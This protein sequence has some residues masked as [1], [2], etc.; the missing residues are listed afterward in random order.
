[1]STRED[2][3]ICH[4]DAHTTDYDLIVLALFSHDLDSLISLTRARYECEDHRDEYEY[5]GHMTPY[6]DKIS[7]VKLK[8]EENT[9]NE[10]NEEYH[11][12]HGQ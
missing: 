2:L 12:H 5:L 11:P 6:Y 8:S 9:Y 3:I 7:K 4:P 10:A 1:M